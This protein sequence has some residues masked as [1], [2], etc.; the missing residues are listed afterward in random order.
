MKIEKLRVLDRLLREKISGKSNPEGKLVSDL[1]KK[2]PFTRAAMW[3]FAIF[4]PLRF[5]VKTILTISE[6]LKI[7]WFLV[8]STL[9]MI[10]CKDS[11]KP[12]FRGAK[13]L[14]IADFETLESQK[15][16]FT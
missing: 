11:L 6:A 10:K 12:Y 3:D 15:L 1:M 8:N 16:D 4:L 7:F 2:N 9:A 13:T 14:K 5:C